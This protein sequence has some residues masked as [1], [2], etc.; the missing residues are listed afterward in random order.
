MNPTDFLS[1]SA[2]ATLLAL[3]ATFLGLAAAVQI[4]QEFW[5]HLSRSEARTYQKVLIDFAGPW[6]Q[7]LLQPGVLNDL[8]VRGPFQLRKVRPKGVLLPLPKDELLRAAERVA[9]V[10][11]RRTIEQLQV[12]RELQASD[13]NLDRSPAWQQLLSEMQ[14]LDPEDPTFWDAERVRD[15]LDEWRE[16]M[17]STRADAFSSHF[18][19][20]S[21]LTF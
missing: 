19:G 8:E 10:W 21:F 14:T 16:K 9:P 7:Q 6:I 2:L 11:V 3:A 20:G 15:F 18:G 4:L 13:P 17:S 12:E 1:S 5:K